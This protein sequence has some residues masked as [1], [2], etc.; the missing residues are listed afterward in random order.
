M[1]SNNTANGFEAL[2]LNNGSANTANGYQALFSNTTGEGNKAIGYDANVS[3][4]NLTNA[5]AIGYGA[6]V[7]ASNKVRIGNA[8]VTV[9][10]GQVAWSTPS[11]RRLK[12]NI[13]VNNYLGLNFINKLQPVTYNY[14]LDNTK[15]RH[16][17]F[18]AQDIEQVMKDLNL[19]FS[20]LKKSSDGMYSLA[21]SDFVMPL[22]NAVKEQKTMIDNQQ[23]QIGNQQIQIDELKKMVE[24]M[25]KK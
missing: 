13:Q 2:K 17:G 4:D 23:I 15:V 24:S 19:P 25:L 18:I 11:D 16:D 12:E 7:N 22:V 20:G 10:E 8:S 5:T 1:G 9:I 21:Y 3:S 6:R 14:I